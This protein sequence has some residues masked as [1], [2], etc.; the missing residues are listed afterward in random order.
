MDIWSD[1]PVLNSGAVFA[2]VWDGVRTKLVEDMRNDFRALHPTITPRLT[3]SRGNLSMDKIFA[4]LVS[5][6]APS[7]NPRTQAR[8]AERF[9]GLLARVPAERL[10]LNPDRGMSHNALG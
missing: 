9:C 3:L 10:W 2:R 8:E 1:G 4:T 6:T 5:G 7:A